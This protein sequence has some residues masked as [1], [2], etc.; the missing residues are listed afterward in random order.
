MKVSIIGFYSSSRKAQLTMI[1]PLVRKLE[2]SRKITRIFISTPFPQLECKYKE[3]ARFKKLQVIDFFNF[4]SLV[5]SLSHSSIVLGIFG[6]SLTNRHNLLS[7]FYN[8]FLFLLPVFLRKKLALISVTLFMP[9]FPNLLK[10]GGK[11]VIYCSVRD[12]KSLLLGRKFFKGNCILRED[13]S[14]S[15]FEEYCPKKGNKRLIVCLRN[16]SYKIANIK[17]NEYSKL[18][19]RLIK[20]ICNLMNINEVSFLAL[21]FGVRKIGMDY[22]LHEEIK[23]EL[24][25]NELIISSKKCSLDLSSLIKEF[26][27]G[28]VV[29]TSRFHGAIFSVSLMKPFLVIDRDYKT[30]YF[31][32]KHNIDGY[33]ISP[34][35]IL[36]ERKVEKILKLIPSFAKSL[37]ILRRKVIKESK[38]H[39]KEI[40]SLMMNNLHY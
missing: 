7:Q 18:I 5:K 14:F 23:K 29:L 12:D 34:D 6:D 11:N 17:R 37:K 40:T 8:Y 35:D 22:L 4:L 13:V 27:S 30:F 21:D 31:M 16:N 39:L 1:I 32:K 20:K 26:E 36:N 3:L 25:K 28:S 2:S 24:K 19:A 15:F 9:A 33:F 10:L 38:T